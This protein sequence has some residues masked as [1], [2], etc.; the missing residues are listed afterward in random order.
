MVALQLLRTV[1]TAGELDHIKVGTSRIT[2]GAA[3]AML[4]IKVKV[5]RTHKAGSRMEAT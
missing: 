2:L 3:R 5:K 4:G 1:E